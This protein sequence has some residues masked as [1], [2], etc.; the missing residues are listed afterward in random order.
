VKSKSYLPM[1][2]E[3][4]AWSTLTIIDKQR[5]QQ[6]RRVVSRALSD[7]AL[8][9]FELAMLE[10]MDVF[11]EQL[12]GPVDSEGWSSPKH[13]SVLCKFFLHR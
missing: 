3:E 9:V 6:R 11:L 12:G 2:P 1:A 10:H 7:S 4:G 8:R 13:M 5:R